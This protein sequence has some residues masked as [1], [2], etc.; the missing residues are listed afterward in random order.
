VCSSPGTVN[1]LNFSSF[2]FSSFDCFLLPPWRSIVGFQP[3]CSIGQLINPLRTHGIVVMPQMGLVGGETCNMRCPA[4]LILLARYQ[5][6]TGEGRTAT[7]TFTPNDPKCASPPCEW[8]CLGAI[9]LSACG[10]M[11]QDQDWARPHW[12][13]FHILEKVHR[14]QRNLTTTCP[15]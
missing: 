4:T 10:Y 11:N 8:L 3:C 6:N 15:R 13:V 2:F 12:E 1:Q 7:G 9:E 14:S 5:V